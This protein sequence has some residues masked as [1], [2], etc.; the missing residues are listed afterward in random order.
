MYLTEFN[1]EFKLSKKALSSCYMLDHKLHY[2]PLCNSMSLY[3]MQRKNVF[4][5]LLVVA[6]NWCLKAQQC[7]MPTDATVPLYK[8]LNI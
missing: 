5:N 1:K 8:I 3:N 6:P 4:Y 7:L 2:L